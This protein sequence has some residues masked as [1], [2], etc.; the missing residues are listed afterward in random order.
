[1]RSR[2]TKHT[3]VTIAVSG[4]VTAASHSATATKLEA[5]TRGSER[6]DPRAHLRLSH[7]SGSS[8][9]TIIPRESVMHHL[10]DGVPGPG[11]GSLRAKLQDQM[12]D[13]SC[14][15]SIMSFNCYKPQAVQCHLDW[16]YLS[17]GPGLFQISNREDGQRLS[18]GSLNAPPPIILNHTSSQ[19]QM[20]SHVPSND[21]AATKSPHQ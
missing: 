10:V 17:S 1:M 3:G 20:P 6:A 19:S 11:D 9:R 5:V 18:W 14:V 15:H 13:A 2:D 21:K 12:R 16:S 8:G 7:P 4:Q